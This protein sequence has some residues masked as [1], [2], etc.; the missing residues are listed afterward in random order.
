[1]H[2]LDPDNG[3]LGTNGIVGGGVPLATGAALSQKTLGG[4][5]VAVTFFGDGAMNQGIVPEC[6]NMAS[7]WSLPVIYVCENN[8]YGEFTRTDEVTAGDS[9]AARGEVLGIP[10]V[11]VDG[12]D[13]LA[14]KAAADTAAR[15][16]REGKGPSFMVCDTWR[17]SGH[18]AGD[19]QSYK[20]DDEA[21]AWHARD[22]IGALGRELVVKGLATDA[23]LEGIQTEVEDEM[24]RAAEIA[25]ADPE[26]APD[27]VW[28]HL[29]AG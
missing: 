21:R 20:D 11:E 4:H 14:V 23:D 15:R 10:S 19:N 27:T 5:G 9:I 16:A 17:Y 22:P 18:H 24:A 29:Y 6:M 3:N 13:V 2:I 25:R 1:M 8:H 7:I 26:P 28:E 12:M